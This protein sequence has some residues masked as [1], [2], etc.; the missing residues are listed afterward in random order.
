VPAEVNG[1][2]EPEA[3][4]A[5]LPKIHAPDREL[6]AEGVEAVPTSENG[7]EEAPKRKRTRRGSRGG[8]RR[9]KPQQASAEPTGEA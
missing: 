4:E 3:A 2:V 9:R 1:P 6:G 5:M 8:K 7:A